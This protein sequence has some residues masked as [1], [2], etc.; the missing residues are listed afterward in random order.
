MN[1]VGNGVLVDNEDSRYFFYYKPV[2]S[3]KKNNGKLLRRMIDSA[4]KCFLKARYLGGAAGRRLVIDYI[5]CKGGGGGDGK[6]LMCTAITFLQ[7]KLDL[8]DEAEVSLLAIADVGTHER[9]NQGKNKSLSNAERENK[10]VAYYTRTYGFEEI[11]S[12][13]GT[14][15]STTI[16][17]IKA[18]CAAE[19]GGKRRGTRRKKRAWST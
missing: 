1:N 3:Y 18:K 8:N 7:K 13:V 10:L 12:G 9:E 6:T 16:G 17:T 2:R 15:M 11:Y 14:H 19:G 4:Y 5:Y